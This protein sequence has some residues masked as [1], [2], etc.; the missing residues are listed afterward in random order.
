VDNRNADILQ[1]KKYLEG[2]LDQRAMYE[3]ERRALG[4][5]F[6]M[7]AMEGY[8][9]AGNQN[10]AA[11]HL[12]NALQNRLQ[13]PKARVIFMRR[14][15]MAAS[16]VAVLTVGGWWLLSKREIDKPTVIAQAK[17]DKT[18]VNRAP[19]TQQPEIAISK[20][21]L[22]ALNVPK[23]VIRSKRSARVYRPG[24]V[25]DIA[26][27]SDETAQL[28][29][30]S[31]Q[32]SAVLEEPSMTMKSRANTDSVPL[33]EMVVIEFGRQ[34]RAALVGAVPK[35]L[36]ATAPLPNVVTGKVI[37]AENGQPLPGVVVTNDKNSVVTDANGT[38][39]LNIDSVNKGIAY[40]FL[41]FKT[42]KLIA[43]NGT[44]NA[45]LEPNTASLN[46]VVIAGYGAARRTDAPH[47]AAGWESYNTYL[48]DSSAS[49]INKA[50]NIRVTFKV[51]PEGALSAFKTNKA[52]ND[53]AGKKAIEI[54]KNGPEWVGISNGQDKK[55]TITVKFYVPKK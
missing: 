32:Q 21:T 22:L 26:A 30:S 50:V 42:Q 41:G 19:L 20:D 12:D 52:D 49:P 27:I 4:D 35:A 38:Y 16:V 5:P 9:A 6:L 13:K 55:V 7:D 45:V 54:I 46:E 51:S 28:A 3:L 44:I 14:L 10:K 25:S 15:A 8:E 43:A 47:P 24:T 33:N 29:M 37:N 2:K 40:N 48:K 11:A 31:V 1:I 36:A 18:E 17:V 53:I 39:Q 34:R 23:S